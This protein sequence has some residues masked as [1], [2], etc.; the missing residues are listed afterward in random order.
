MSQFCRRLKQA[1]SKGFTS[2]FHL[3]QCKWYKVYPAFVCPL[4]KPES[5][6]VVWG[7]AW[8]GR[9]SGSRCPPTHTP[10]GEG[11]A[12]L[13]EMLKI[14]ISRTWPTFRLSLQRL[15][16]ASQMGEQKVQKEQATR[17]VTIFICRLIKLMQVS[18]LS[19]EPSILRLLPGCLGGKQLYCSPLQNSDVL[20]GL[21]Q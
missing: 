8:V 21:W 6:C 11:G 2:L 17:R 5:R 16:Y 13:W 10:G 15:P 18:P 14:W 7:N 4:K 3:F 12:Q 1:F 9:G 19:V 20:Y